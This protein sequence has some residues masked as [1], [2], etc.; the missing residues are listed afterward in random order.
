MCS[1]PGG[2]ENA[3]ERR[4]ATYDI[5]ELQASMLRSLA[6][7]HRL[8]ILHLLGAQ[9]SEVNE[10]ARKLGLSQAAASQHLS[11]MRAVG[12]V[13]AIRD[14]RTVTYRLADPQILA[15]C[16][17]MRA[18]LVRR[19]SRLGDLA[20]AAHEPVVDGLLGAEVHHS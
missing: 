10:I 18:V 20:A 15:A 13:Q 1:A 6:S 8:R 2:S 17:L 4:S 5:D 7:A 16:E 11:A 14:G 3:M 12:L 9:P 19:L